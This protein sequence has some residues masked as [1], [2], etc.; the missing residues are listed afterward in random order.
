MTLMRMPKEGGKCEPVEGELVG[1]D[2]MPYHPPLEWPLYIQ[3]A[4]GSDQDGKI[5]VVKQNGR[6]TW[7]KPTKQQNP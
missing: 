3:I 6:W 2:E 5:M 7:L 4:N 1:Q